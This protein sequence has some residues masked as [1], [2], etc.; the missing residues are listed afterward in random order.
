MDA[1]KFLILVVLLLIV[2]MA[3]TLWGLF[4]ISKQ[5]RQL[6]LDLDY[7]RLKL[8]EWVNQVLFLSSRVRTFAEESSDW[9]GLVEAHFTYLDDIEYKRRTRKELP[10]PLTPFSLRKQKTKKIEPKKVEGEA[11]G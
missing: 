7:E 8:N 3:L 9:A 4:R 2:V 10:R 1:F 5:I 11:G 6:Q